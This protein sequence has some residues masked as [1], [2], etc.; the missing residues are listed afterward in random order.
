MDTAEEALAAL[1]RDLIEEIAAGRVL[2]LAATSAPPAQA[3]APVEIPKPKKGAAAVHPRLGGHLLKQP[4]DS[5]SG[6]AYAHVP[7]MFPVKAPDARDNTIA[8][9]H[10]TLGIHRQAEAQRLDAEQA[11][12][13]A[14][15]TGIPAPG[16]YAPL[17]D[18][19]YAA[20]ADRAH[21]AVA[22]ELAA[23]HSTDKT[24]TLDGKGQV[25]TPERAAVHNE[26]VRGITDR[27]VGVP[28]EGKAVV[29]GGLAGRAKAAVLK[30]AIDP[31][32]ARGGQS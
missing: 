23:G 16:T 19:Q 7:Q 5:V 14:Q 15:R 10:Q 32:P 21:H 13:E 26:I 30:K 17:D 29:A 6:H 8:E 4:G 22:G 12:A 25:W 18:E 28:S 31:G 2:E 24:E 3:P 11:A 20:H 1:A 9:L 27:A